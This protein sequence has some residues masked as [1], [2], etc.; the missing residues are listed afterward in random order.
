MNLEQVK[1]FIRTAN[2]EELSEIRTVFNT[3]LRIIQ[4]EERDQFQKGDMVTVNHENY[5][6]TIIYRIVR[7]N[8]KTITINNDIIGTL[9]ASPKLLKMAKVGSFPELK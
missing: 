8:K 7:I 3:A 6:P 1:D 9:K 2:R 5:D 4:Q